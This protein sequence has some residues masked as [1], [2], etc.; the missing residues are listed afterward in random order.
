[1]NCKESHKITNIEDEDLKC[2]EHNLKILYTSKNSLSCQKCLASSKKIPINETEI[3]SVLE[4]NYSSNLEYEIYK[5]YKDVFDCKKR[6]REL[7]E[8]MEIILKKKKINDDRIDF[9]SKNIQILENVQNSCGMEL[10]FQYKNFIKN[11]MFQ[12]FENKKIFTKILGFDSKKNKTLVSISTENLNIIDISCGFEYTHF[13]DENYQLYS[14]GKND[15]GQLGLGN[16]DEVNTLTHNEFFN[17]KK[18]I[19]IST[20]KNYTLLLAGIHL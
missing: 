4:M 6:N 18:I 16:Y 14:K 8:E 7:D 1:L 12:V 3:N 5:K 20:G 13:L 11:S 10:F 9:E 19:K 15:I 17:D 2:K